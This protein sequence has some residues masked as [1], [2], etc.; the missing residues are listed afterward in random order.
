MVDG[1]AALSSIFKSYHEGNRRPANPQHAA[2]TSWAASSPHDAMR[3]WNALPEGQVKSDFARSL[4]QGVASRDANL[5]WNCMKAFPANEQGPFMGVLLRQVVADSGAEAAARFI[6]S[7]PSGESAEAE[8]LKQAGFDSL[9]QSVV[10]YTPE[11]K[12]QFVSRFSESAWMADSGHADR[13]AADWAAK[14]G[15]ASVQWADKLPEG[16]RPKA[17][18]AALRA[19]S[20]KQGESYQ[21]WAAEHAADPRFADAIKAASGEVSAP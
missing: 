11:K 17:L 4:I 1:E 12:S 7:L 14:D 5:A 2:M 6:E 18:Q 9:M 20:Q 8:A 10:N 15:A 16:V 13:I 21:K 19:W 3:W